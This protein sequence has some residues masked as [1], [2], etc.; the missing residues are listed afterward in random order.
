MRVLR[1]IECTTGGTLVMPRSKG[2]WRY[3][4]DTKNTGVAAEGTGVLV[5]STDVTTQS[6][7]M[8]LRKMY[9][10][11]RS[12]DGCTEDTEMILRSTEVATEDTEAVLKSDQASC[13]GDTEKNRGCC[14]WYWCGISKLEGCY[15]G[16]NITSVLSVA[17]SV[18]L[19]SPT[20][21]MI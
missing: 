17:T 14:W 12:T 20:A 7:E 2:Y 1:S 4:G 21:S 13:K 9:E 18:L 10:L 3:W 8:I 19:V 5:R 16:L 6:T 15:R 11:L